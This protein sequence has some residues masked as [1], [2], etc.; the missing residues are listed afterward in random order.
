MRLFSFRRSFVG[1]F[2]FASM[3]IARSLQRRRLR[4]RQSEMS[5]ARLQRASG[6]LEM[7]QLEQRLALA[8]TAYSEPS[9]VTLL[10]SSGSDLYLTQTV[11]AT[12]SQK[13]LWVSSASTF[14]NASKYNLLQGSSPVAAGGSGIGVESGYVSS[15]PSYDT[16]AVTTGT[17]K[18]ET[19]IRNSGYPMQSADVDSTDPATSR[20]ARTT[21]FVLSGTVTMFGKNGDDGSVVPDG[22]QITGSIQCTQ[23]DNLTISEWTFDRYGAIVGRKDSQGGVEVST[24][25]KDHPEWY[26]PVQVTFDK[27]FNGQ[28]NYYSDGTQR[29]GGSDASTAVE[30]LW[31][32]PLSARSHVNLASVTARLFN[33]EYS[34]NRTEVSVQPSSPR[35]SVDSASPQTVFSLAGASDSGS[36]GIVSGTLSGEILIKSEWGDGHLAFTTMRGDSRLRFY[37]NDNLRGGNT[38]LQGTITI[39]LRSVQVVGAYDAAG[40]VALRF[41]TAKSANSSAGQ[42]DPYGRSIGRDQLVSFSTDESEHYR[43]YPGEIMLSAKY[44]VNETGL[45]ANNLTL[46]A[47]YDVSNSLDVDLLTPGSTVHVDSPVVTAGN[48]SMGATNILFDAAVRA[49]GVG[50]LLEIKAPDVSLAGP[51]GEAAPTPVQAAKA[52]AEVVG[53]KVL[54]LVPVVG[55]EGAG[56]DRDAAPIVRI[57]APAGGQDAV[58]V[59]QVSPAGRITGYTPQSTTPQSTGSGFTTTP[60]VSVPAPISV[61]GATGALA[62]VNPATGAI[63]GISLA[64]KG[65]GYRSIPQVTVAPPAASAGGRQ[66]TAVAVLDNDGRITGIRVTDGGSGYDPAQPPRVFVAKPNQIAVPESIAFNT[67][68]SAAY[69]RIAVND[70]PTT[71]PQRGRLLVSQTSVLSN[72]GS[73]AGDLRVEATQSDLIIEGRIDVTNQTYY[74]FSA[75]EVASLTAG[76]PNHTPFLFTTRSLGGEQTGVIRGDVLQLVLANDLPTPANDSSVAFDVV[77]L[78]TDVRSLRT[79][80]ATRAGEVRRDPF[81]YLLTIDEVNDLGVD[82]V[83]ASSFP[84]VFNV[85]GDMQFNATVATAGDVVIDVARDFSLSAPVQTTL[86]RIL[87]TADNVFLDSTLAVTAAAPD[88]TRNDIEV[89]ARGGDIRVNSNITAVNRVALVQNNVLGDTQTRRASTGVPVAIPDGGTASATIDLAGAINDFTFEKLQVGIK[90]THTWDSDLSAVLI[91]PNG[92]RFRLFGRV[93][94]S[95]DNFTDTVFSSDATQ[96]ISASSAVAPFTGTYQPQDSL[97]PL[98][99]SNALGIWKLEVADSGGGDVGTI[100]AFQLVFVKAS[101]LEGQIVGTGRIAADGLVLRADGDVGNSRLFP[102]DSRMF[103]RTSVNTL[104]ATVANAVAIDESDSIDILSLRAGGLVTL[105]ANGFDTAAGPALRAELFD[106]TQLDVSAPNGSVSIE[107]VTSYDL[108]LGNAAAIRIGKALN[109]T[110]AGNVS[111]KTSGGST[112]SS[113]VVLDAPLAGGGARAVRALADQA[114][115]GVYLPQTPGLYASTI[116]G[117]SVGKLESLLGGIANLRAGDRILVAGGV[118]AD[119]GTGASSA[120]G[121]YA[122]TQLGSDASKWVL[123]RAA[124]SDIQSETPTN[125]FVRVSDGGA[126]G[127]VYKL[128][129]AATDEL[130]FTK[131]PITVAPV[132]LGTNIGSEDPNVLVNYV[133]ASEAG[134]NLAAGAL[135][136]MIQLANTNAYDAGNRDSIYVAFAD[137][138]ATIALTEELPKI[139]RRLDIDGG[140]RF[141]VSV[142]TTN[143]AL[144]GSRIATTYDGLTVSGN[145]TRTIAGINFSGMGAAGSRLANL[146]LGGFSGSTKVGG[147]AA[148]LIDSAS[149]VL[150][151]NVTIGKNANGGKLANENGVIVKGGAA[152][153]TIKDAVVVGSTAAGVRV[154]DTATDVTTDVT[155]FGSTI[156]QSGLDNRI[157]VEMVG[158]GANR[159]GKNAIASPP[160]L[161]AKDAETFA[162]DPQSNFPIQELFVGQGVS[163]GDALPSGTKIIA[164]DEATKVVTLSAAALRTGMVTPVFQLPGRNT[165]QWNLYGV[166][167]ADGSNTVSNTDVVNN[168]FAGIQIQGG[169]QTI[170]EAKARTAASNGIYLNQGWGI[171]VEPSTASYT[172]KAAVDLADQQTIQGN[173]F[174]PAGTPP[175]VTTSQNKAGAIGIKESAAAKVAAYV[176]PAYTSSVW[177]A[178][179]NT[180]A[181]LQGNRYFAVPDLVGPL[182]VLV[183][184]RDAS[185]AS[186]FDSNTAESHVRLETGAARLAK[187][188]VIKLAD[189]DSGIDRQTVVKEAFTLSRNGTALI[190][191][192]DYTFR[193]LGNDEVFIDSQ[194]TV[195]PLGEYRVTMVSRAAQ[196][197]IPDVQVAQLGW[198]TDVANNRLQSQ[199]PLTIALVDVPGVPGMKSAVAGDAGASLTWTVPVDN[200]SAIT[201][202]AIE[203]KSGAVGS[204]WERFLHLPST[205]TAG[206]VTGLANGGSY[207][208][209]V[210]ATN[211]LGRGDFSEASVAVTP[212]PVPVVAFAADGGTNPSDGITPNGLV[213]VMRLTTGAQWEYS[214]TG[215]SVWRPGSGETFSLVP[216]S[217]P[218]GSV[219][220][221]QTFQGLTS[222]VGSNSIPFSVDL[223]VP[224]LAITSAPVGL[225]RGE[226]GVISLTLSEASATFTASSVAVSGGT[227]SGFTGSGSSYTALLTPSAGV[228]SA[229][230][231]VDAGSFKDLA[232][233]A[234]TVGASLAVAVDTVAPTILVTSSRLALHRGETAVITFALSEP[235]ATF[236]LGAVAVTGGTLSSLS[237][238]GDTYTAVLTPANDSQAPVA[239][240]VAAG[241]FTDLLGNP[242]EASNALSIAVDTVPPT[243]LITSA[244][245]FL[246]SGQTALITFAVSKTDTAFSL[247]AVTVT[248]GALSAFSGGAGLYTA[249]FTPAANAATGIVVIEA[250]AFTDTAGNGNIGASTSIAIDALMPTIAITTSPVALRAGETATIQFI[251]SEPSTTFTLADVAVSGGVLS[252]FSGRG[253]AY[254]AVFTPA[255]NSAIPGLVAVAVGAFTD[256]ADNPSQGGGSVS[257]GVDTVLPAITIT[258]GSAAV[259]NGETATIVFALSKLSTTFTAADV[260]VDGGSL[261]GFS[262]SGASYTATFTPRADFVGTATISVAA[263]TFTDAAGNPNGTGGSTGIAVN[264]QLPTIAVTPGA[265]ILG[266]G[267][268]TRLGFLLSQDSTDFTASDISVVGGVLSAFVGSGSAYSATFTPAADF[269]GTASFTVAVNAFTNA[270]GNGNQTGGATFTVDTTPPRVVITSSQESLKSG[271]T[272]TLTF[273]LSEPSSTFTQA[274]VYPTG[275]TISGWRRIDSTTYQVTFT[276]LADTTGTAYVVVYDGAFSDA[277]G[278]PNVGDAGCIIR[279]LAVDTVAPAVAIA[280]TS[281]QLKKDEAATLTF[282]LSKPS[283][284]FTVEDVYPT[285]GSV[286]DFT[287]VSPSLYTCRFSP[288]PTTR[289]GYVVV[290]DNTFTDIAGNGVRSRDG[291]VIQYFSVDAVPPTVEISAN[292]TTLKA[293]ESAQVRFTLSEPSADF[294]AGKVY[295]NGGVLSGFTG[296]GT[297]YTATFTPFANTSGTATLVVYDNTFTDL[298]GN[299]N[300]SPDGY[301]IQLFSVD[302]VAP[303]VVSLAHTGSGTLGVGATVAITANL[304]KP[305]QAGGAIDVTLDTGDVVRLTTA[306]AGRVLSGTYTIQPGRSST[307]LRPVA[308]GATAFVVKD[309][310]GNVLASP[311]PTEA[312][313]RG[314][315]IAVKAEIA[316]TAAG[317]SSDARRV[318]DKRTAVKTVTVTFSTAVYGVQASDFK[319]YFNNR[320]L[321]MSGVGVRGSG[322]TYTITLPSRYTSAKGIYT[323]QIGPGGGIRAVAN[324]ALMTVAGSIYW[325]NGSRR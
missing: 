242:N 291:Y 161:L 303:A 91:A 226:T 96:S 6:R 244:A 26:L 322:T 134:T 20:L 18:I 50:S 201:D 93:G 89:T 274:G 236:A 146:S 203:F 253:S 168:V 320:L 116:V 75:P 189:D 150:V 292:I 312:G 142:T 295:A 301:R 280:T 298:A 9:A 61:A 273:K 53:G 81:P 262:G 165:I 283:T 113:I 70:D 68:V 315:V 209:R 111:I 88:D 69:Y 99:G 160:V 188:F 85:G 272:A 97:L 13:D 178:A 62:T 263:G 103:L 114:L 59:A 207:R 137:N 154:E 39:G 48:V 65:Y 238:S 267:Q 211:I 252:E 38:A 271:D 213:Q 147:D 311:V 109:S 104:E 163:A 16:I 284:T 276:P 106:V 323:L 19:N 179:A 25:I 190:E 128:G 72:G 105:R 282:T 135:G 37:P 210:A 285:G 90:I 149:D 8:V 288:S 125:T 35:G 132:T 174:I 194:E 269:T 255:V 108:T 249:I 220:V 98:A 122:V 173:Y 34:Y 162:F 257:I 29:A 92:S 191:G 44:A 232:G 204:D 196:P 199:G 143:V 54:R 200:G 10:V 183:A 101:P 27:Y 197:A 228:T 131:A 217:Y 281:A 206:L 56:Y 317:F 80:A 324:G 4:S 289:T 287:R 261:S 230:V 313:W 246:R 40:K 248:G 308:Y 325:G 49:T 316:A 74:L 166:R 118:T 58:F 124:D 259:R 227:L 144:D 148:V 177:N 120:N 63:T 235:V 95:G 156:G 71:D 307:N 306:T 256:S 22:M 76:Y 241:A 182:A 159:I 41:Y 43:Q 133:V 117:S 192:N 110:A 224:G 14:E 82:A 175:G 126:A 130:R 2:S 240:N 73:A 171:L 218:A 185:G 170:G 268:S 290:Y 172:K 129:Y 52:I 219:Q 79:R 314:D 265:T 208:F 17:E 321:I 300:V 33:N 141:G 245:A 297:S 279:Y 250:N 293:G 60:T 254:T 234:N 167:L 100:D 286:S 121:V 266:R 5:Q 115:A 28:Y 102:A 67:L 64:T 24:E 299:G 304:S 187:T 193:Y 164:I 180:G 186:L 237:G 46:F 139:T 155:I 225:R 215:G 23:P 1:L 87:I 278:N 309:L 176:S 305:V 78:K 243:V 140:N 153:V 302:A 157:G 229:T 152:G 15:I 233:N 247:D 169:S 221:R 57:A 158:T 212:L 36:L 181:D 45:K 310:A 30:V 11:G 94:G 202:Y 31:N 145:T 195:F 205:A 151:E 107:D 84:L 260:A 264:T 86:G 123:T 222:P 47:G 32:T 42:V 12:P 216:G 270:A 239:I 127:R 294:N 223:I 7:Q 66:A 277:A 83:A 77:E 198:L 231:S 55:A 136:K 251:L 184:P 214:T 138:I 319:L 318:D 51:F 275:G 296:S 3:G 119:G 258:A 21:A 112:S